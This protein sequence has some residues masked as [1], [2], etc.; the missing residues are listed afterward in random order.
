VERKLNHHDHRHQQRGPAG[1]GDV[2][3]LQADVQ[4]LIL[5]TL[6]ATLPRP[7][8]TDEEAEA[9]AEWLYGFVWQQSEMAA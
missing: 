8:F 6:Y 3:R 9:L 4:V 7:P 2:R 5:D 1:A